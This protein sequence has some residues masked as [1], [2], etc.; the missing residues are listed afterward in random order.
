MTQKILILTLI[1]VASL[2]LLNSAGAQQGEQTEAAA[3]AEDNTERSTRD[4]EDA[5]VEAVLK[6]AELVYEND[7]DFIPSQQVSADQSIDFPIDI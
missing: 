5:E 7:D 6:D 2:Q 4:A 1:A 3:T